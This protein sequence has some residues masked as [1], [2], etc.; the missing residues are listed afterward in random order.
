MGAGKVTLPLPSLP[1]TPFC[2]L[3]GFLRTARAGARPKNPVAKIAYVTPQ[4]WRRFCAWLAP[5]RTTTKKRE[6]ANAGKRWAEDEFG[7]AELG[8][9]LRS[10][11]LVE[12]ARAVLRQP[13]GLVTEVFPDAGDR[14]GAYKFLENEKIDVSAI[15]G[16]ACEAAAL[17]AKGMP[18]VF[19][20]VD[21]SSLSLREY[22]GEAER[23]VG[24]IGS[25]QRRGT[26]VEV[27]NAIVID[28]IGVPV[29]LLDQQWWV[30]TGPVKT[31]HWKRKLEEKET[32]HWLAAIGAG[33]QQW[34]AANEETRL[35]FQLDRGGDFRE[36]LA[37]A[38]NTHHWVT[39]RAAH[40]RRVLDS[41]EQY[42]WATLEGAPVATK[43]TIAISKTKKRAARSA[44][45]ELRYAK[46]TLRLRNKW[47]K[48]CTEATL[49]ALLARETGQPADGTEP[50]EWLLLTNHEI[51]SAKDAE[52]VLFGYTQR[53]R[54]EQFHKTWK[55]VCKVEKT[56]LRELSHIERWATILAAVAMRLL[57]LTYLARQNPGLPATVA[58]S[59]AEVTALIIE[60]SKGTMGIGDALTIGQ[61]TRWIAEMGGYVG[62]RSAGGPPGTIVLARG[63]RRLADS[64]ETISKVLEFVH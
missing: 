34:T 63:M 57:R 48:A 26:G 12:I 14:E 9:L 7:R 2:R 50:V 51:Q 29:G 55:S 16:A 1:F 27:M 56:Q 18:Y 39:V 61:A 5:M 40:D 21:G 62:I 10:E 42:L 20:P 60:K 45:L 44:T 43:Q 25:R 23:G 46:V 6:L 33:T 47:T 28:P 53:W 64:A 30:R 38:E 49:W 19:V 59:R 31:N 13:A 41:E 32:R 11:R 22:E 37:W 58:L 17:R 35:W 36:M 15:A 4:T 52:L 54:V 3:V 8:N 24:S